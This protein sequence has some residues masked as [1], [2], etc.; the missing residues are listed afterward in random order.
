MNVLVRAALL[1]LV[2][3]PLV[4]PAAPASSC[5]T[6]AGQSIPPPSGYCCNRLGTLEIVGP[7]GKLYYLDMRQTVALVFNNT[8]PPMP[9]LQLDGGVA[10]LYAESNQQTGLQRGGTGLARA[11]LCR[12]SAPVAGPDAIVV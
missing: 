4:P 10:W 7:D 12:D 11:D 8:V 2:V 9:R 3:I 1:A 5:V 6:Y